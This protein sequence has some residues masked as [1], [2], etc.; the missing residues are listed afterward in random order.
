MSRLLKPRQIA[1]L[2]LIRNSKG[3]DNEE[4]NYQ[5]IIKQIRK[6]HLKAKNYGTKSRAYWLV[7]EAEIKRYQQ[8]VNN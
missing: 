6:G 7:S 2:A 5:F 4:A 8:E 1:K 3:Q